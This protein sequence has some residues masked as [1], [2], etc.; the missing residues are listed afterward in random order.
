[1]KIAPLIV[2]LS[3]SLFANAQQHYCGTVMSPQ[4][5]QWLDNYKSHGY[6]LYKQDEEAAL[7]YIP[8]KIHLVGKDDG[9]GYLKNQLLL[10]GLCKLNEQYEQVGFHFYIYG[11][12]DYMKSTHVYDAPGDYWN[13]VVAAKEQNALNLYYVNNADGNCG[14]YSP[15]GDYVIIAKMCA[16]S[17]NSTV[18]HEV[19][20]FFDLPHTFSG[21]EGRAQSDAPKAT[22]ERVN[23]SNC[24]TAGDRF[25][26]T[27]ADF[28]SDRWSCPY[29]GTKTDYVGQTYNVDG[30]LFMSYANDGCQNRFSPEQLDVMHAYLNDQRAAF[31]SYPKPNTDTVRATQAVYPA[32][33]VNYVPANFAQLKWRK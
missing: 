25:C 26:D 30:T 18:A 5:M 28:I 15:G 2:V 9:T 8:L 13:E 20:H 16:G 3:I 7:Q 21:W 19:G 23:G 32:D 6:P 24:H 14:Y 4:M 1:M 31:L 17:A 27:P 12:I 22:D 11:E 29:T 10:D 33:S